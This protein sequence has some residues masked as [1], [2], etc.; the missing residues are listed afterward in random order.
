[1]EDQILKI[2]IKCVEEILQEGDKSVRVD[3]STQL[4]GQNGILDSLGLVRVITNIEEAISET[5][6]KDI[7]I[8]SEKAM[9][10]KNSPFINVES[11]S[12]FIVEI[13]NSG[14]YV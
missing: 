3:K 5:F 11:L 14:E 13:L 4:Y 6:G 1:M 10:R 9:S 2:V 12:K 8:A 7:V